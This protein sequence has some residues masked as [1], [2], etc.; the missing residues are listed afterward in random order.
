MIEPLLWSTEKMKTD[1]QFLVSCPKTSV[2][3]RLINKWTQGNRETYYSI[4]DIQNFLLLFNSLLLDQKN[5]DLKTTES[6]LSSI[7][8]EKTI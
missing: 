6:I 7:P 5:W 8:P 3:N 1:K 2:K 4:S